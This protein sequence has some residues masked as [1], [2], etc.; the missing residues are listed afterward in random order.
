MRYRVLVWFKAELLDQ[1]GL[2]AGPAILKDGGQANF[3]FL[4]GGRLAE[5]SVLACMS[6]A[7]TSPSEVKQF[8]VKVELHSFA[9]NSLHDELANFTAHSFRLGII[10]PYHRYT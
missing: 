8:G 10:S 9:I 1:V 6:R 4:V 7:T 2:V 5:T 3:P